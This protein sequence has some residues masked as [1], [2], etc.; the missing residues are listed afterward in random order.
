MEETCGIGRNPGGTAAGIAA[1]PGT[2]A[3]HIARM[4]GKKQLS[5]AA[6]LCGIACMA[7]VALGSGCAAERANRPQ[8]TESQASDAGVGERLG[9]KPLGVMLTAAGT[10][11]QFRYIVVDPGRSHPVFDQKIKTYLVDQARGTGYDVASETQ[12]GPLRSS[13]RNPVAGKEYFIMFTNPD[14]VVKRGNKVTI[15][16]GEYKIENVTV[17]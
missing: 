12:F 9:I 16:I 13:S 3:P 10:K 5:V 8:G 14:R 6:G 17:D 1:S 11:L 7:I 4:P 2:A 15:V